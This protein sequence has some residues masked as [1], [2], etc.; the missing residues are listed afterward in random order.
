MLRT[1]CLLLGLTLS[2]PALAQRTYADRSVLASG[3]WY[4]IAIRAPG[5]YK[6]D[7]SFLSGL[8]IPIP[9]SSNTI[10]L[11]GNGGKML[12]EKNSVAR[13]D[14]LLEN[15]IWV[16]DG[17]DG[18]FSGQDYFLFYAGGPDGWERDSLNN[19]YRHRKN[20]YGGES[21]Y[22]LTVGGD[23]LRIPQQLAPG[24]ATS[25]T[26]RFEEQYFYELDS[27]NF[28]SSGKEWY[29]EEFGT[30][31][32]QLPARSFNIP[33]SGLVP[34]TP[35][36]VV[37]DVI[38]RSVG[39]ASRFDV[40]L[41]NT[42]LYQHSLPPLQGTL[43]EPIATASQQSATT[44][45]TEN[46][47]QLNLSF[48]PGSVNGQGWLNWFEIFCTRELDMSGSPQL[49][50]RGNPVSG[51][52]QVN[53]YLLKN[54]AGLQA[55]WDVTDPIHPRQMIPEPS[56]SVTRFRDDAP[57]RRTYIAFSGSGFLLPRL[58]GR[59]SNQDLH[60]PQVVGMIILTTASLMGEAQRLAEHHRQAENLVSLVADVEQVYQEFSSGSP[61]PAALRDFVKMFYD[62]AGPDS[63][64][65]PR[66]LLLFGDA[67][68]DYRNRIARNTNLVPA[69]QN[70]ISLDPLNSYTSDDFFGYLDDGD[71]INALI[72]VSYL[73][74]GIGRLPAA[75]PEQARVMVDK[76]T[77]YRS[78]ASMGPWRNQFSLVADDEDQNI[79]L[80]DAELHAETVGLL[81]P[82]LNLQKTYLDAYQQ[83]SGTG[84]S[85]YPRVNESINSRIY[86]GT[87]IW[88]YS[89][90]GSSQRLAQ[91]AIL[92]LDM[93]RSWKNENKLPLFI[94]ATCDFA[95]YDNPL[96]E[97]IGEQILMSQPSGAIA[98]MTTTRLVFAFSNRVMNNN[99]LRFALQ[100]GPDGKYPSLGDAVRTAKNFTYQSSGDVTNNRKFT[101]LGDPALTLGFPVDRI[102]TTSINGTPVGSFTDTLKAL[103]RYTISGEV[104]D[105]NGAPLTDFNGFVYPSV[106][107]KSQQLQTLGND[108][109]S[110]VTGFTVRQNLLY[111]GKVKV[112]NGRFSYTFI[113]PRDI[114]YQTGKGRLSYYGDNGIREASG[115]TDELFVGGLGN[116]VADDGAGPT[117]R[118]WLNDEK[119]VNGGLS[120]ETPVLIISLAD[121]SGI[122]TVGTGIGHNLTAVLDG[123]AG[124]TYVLND[125]YEAE[126]DSYQRGKVRFQLPVLEEGTHS[127]RIRAWDVFNNSNE[128]VLECR[129][130]KQEELEIKHVLNYPNPFTTRTQFW[131]EHNR[132]SENL[133]VTIQVM[134]VGGKLVR[135]I[136][137]T[138]NTGGNRSCEVEW[139]GRDD[140]GARLGRGVYI[141]RLRVRT[142]DGKSR[143]KLE[144]LLIL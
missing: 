23:G 115:F 45:L 57:A 91:E 52:G 95:P 104:T 66:Y 132:P 9:L 79:H 84:G 110:L 117:I 37:T 77:R 61:D 75:T 89:G 135:T 97:S 62:R 88:N 8:G 137:Q 5:V 86:N 2:V 139:D 7:A 56:G 29:G 1:C 53:G 140:Y 50:F 20:L 27:L 101:L 116:E 43:Y 106:Y 128:Y 126:Q 36:T 64:R 12:P 55:I 49:I 44:S 108:P 129:V 105:P 21:F 73:D 33:V 54:A 120:N 78:A 22:F 59:V 98:L 74:V 122:N 18:Q 28:L 113:V 3:N 121:S 119:F 25:E 76:V 112:Q 15:A 16:Q 13:P 69:W 58:V 31:P 118:A 144:K 82:S 103:N 94:T 107:D 109:G 83:E 68:F 30:G 67:S 143:E 124:Q 87:L 131:F 42:L 85:R 34:G 102:R 17:G 32:G 136:A 11:Y 123:N 48:S 14:D 19:T 63:A 6:I 24:A 72:P 80:N 114:N 100:A 60:R 41:N 111:N 26:D 93:V 92:D 39:N 10:R 46:R 35:V 125:F 51:P 65:R 138:I 133:Q 90:H 141:Y 134:T 130:V 142:S 99:Y 38:A 40:R 81:S 71:D 70:A 4:K 96:V 127:I 47:L